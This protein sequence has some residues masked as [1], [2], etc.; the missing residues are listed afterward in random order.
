MEAG[1]KTLIVVTH[2]LIIDQILKYQLANFLVRVRKINS[3]I[4]FLISSFPLVDQFQHVHVNHPW[5]EAT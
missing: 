4:E 2:V 3:I 1:M 5:S